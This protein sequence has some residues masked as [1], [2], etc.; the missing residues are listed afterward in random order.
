VFDL[1]NGSETSLTFH[2]NSQ[3]HREAPRRMT[4]MQSEASRYDYL[5]LI[6]RPRIT[7][8]N[9]ARVAFWVCPNIE[10]YELDPPDGQ[11]RPIWQRP[12]PDVLN[13]SLRDYGN[14][15]GVW[16]V[17]EALERFGVRASVS[18]NAAMCDHLPDIVDE[19]VRLRWEL[20]SHGIYNTR[21]IYGLSEDEVREM[22]RDSVD[23]IR[24]HSGRNVDGFLA[25][26]IS[27]AET[28]L[29][30]LPEFG[31]KYTIDMVPDDQPVPVKVRQ[32]PRGEARLIAV[33]YSTEINDIRVMGMRGHSADQW[34][35]MVK[36]SFDQLYKEGEHNG[37]VACVPLH[38]FVVGHPHRIAA[39]HDVLRHVTS[40]ADVWLATAGEI[41]EWY[42][43]HHYDEA[44][45]HRASEKMVPK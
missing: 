27:S 1:L 9:G 34:A 39:L 33:P 44:V 5:P 17:M 29:D 41:A 3:I 37:M 43:Q 30:L 14:R 12:Y 45:R 20:F 18:L 7:W 42:L 19:C 35:G 10:F 15:S 26:A 24:R 40:H 6:D 22:I 25:P 13:Y 23:T 4:S 2:V 36:A 11:G 28:F 38:P 31:I 16:R 21:L 8:P 32:G